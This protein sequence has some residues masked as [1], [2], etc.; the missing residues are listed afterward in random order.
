MKIVSISA[1]VLLSAGFV[2]AQSHLAPTSDMTLAAT[3]GGPAPSTAIPPSPSEQ[4]AVQQNVKDIHFDFDRA[5][6]R[7]EDQITLQ[8][9]A[10]WLKA[11]PNTLVTIEGDADDRGDIV[12]NVA[13]S[14]KRAAVT[15]DALVSMGVPAD[16]IVY[17]TGWG[18]LYPICSEADE[19]CWSQNRRAH[20][21]A[22]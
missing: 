6:L 1:V 5:E 22:W 14:E 2:L 16:Q 4:Q 8:S 12:Y 18:K 20:F 21:S 7:P 3:A 15:K 13:L 11:N 17:A 19:S 9:D 10:Q